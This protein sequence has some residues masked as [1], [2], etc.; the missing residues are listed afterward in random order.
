MLL[1]GGEQAVNIHDLFLAYTDILN[2]TLAEGG[3][4]RD[5]KSMRENLRNYVTY[6]R[7][8]TK[9][10]LLFGSRICFLFNY[11]HQLKTDMKAFPHKG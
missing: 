3:D 8:V 11:D 6:G 4:W 2:K 7:F 10:L 5:G 9:C 1:Q